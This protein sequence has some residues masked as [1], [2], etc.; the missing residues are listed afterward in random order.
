MSAEVTA[1]SRSTHCRAS[2]ASVCPRCAAM[3]ESA[4][5]QARSLS[6]IIAGFK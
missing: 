1:S 5:V 3:A 4:C 6:S 2:W